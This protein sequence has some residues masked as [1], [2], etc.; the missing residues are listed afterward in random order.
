MNSVDSMFDP[1]PEAHDRLSSP[2][3]WDSTGRTWAS[4][5]RQV[6]TC[7]RVI[8]ETHDVRSFEFRVGDGAPV[9]FEPGQFMTVSANVHGQSVERCYTI[10]S[11]PTRPYLLSITVKRVPGGVMSNWLHDTMR[12][13][14]RM[15]AYGPSGSFTP[16]AAPAAKLLYLSAGSGVTPLMSMTRASIDLGL[17]LD[18]VFVH[19]A[20]TPA[21]IVFRNEL[22]RLEALSPRL[23]TLFVCEGAGNEAPWSGP[24]GRLSLP[25]LAEQVPDY[26]EREAFT[27]GPAGYMIAVRD[28]LRSGGHDPARYHQESFDISA[29]IAPAPAAPADD[30]S[31][32]TFTIKLS[33]SS[34]TFTVNATDT[35]L[36]AARKAGVAIPSSCSQG[37]C[38]TCK[39]KVLEGTVEM[40][41]NGGIRDREVQKGFR[42]LCCSRPTSDLVLEL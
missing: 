13:G 3:T 30:A 33:R 32:E 28:V 12:P 22:Q 7:C 15:L 25:L 6:L 14:G 29:G 10:S 20:R 27:C 24:I 31:S 4:G 2:G 8:D 41:H 11:P 42:L 16:T 18:I 5:E 36:S 19:S 34:R 21:D 40:Q 35:V 9:R 37:I 39:T 1:S 23:R 38:G 17:D 26:A